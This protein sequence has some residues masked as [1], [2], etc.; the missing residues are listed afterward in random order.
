MKMFYVIKWRVCLTKKFQIRDDQK[1]HCPNRDEFAT[2][3]GKRDSESVNS[4]PEEY[5]EGERR[6]HNDI[7]IGNGT[8]KMISRE[9]K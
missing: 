3:W 2:V 6:R 1:I 7:R 5:E 9:F 8:D 4:V